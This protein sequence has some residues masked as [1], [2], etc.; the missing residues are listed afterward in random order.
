MTWP[1]SAAPADADASLTKAVEG[2]KSD[3]AVFPLSPP[4]PRRMLADL[5]TR[6]SSRLR[7]DP[8]QATW[9]FFL[10]THTAPFDDVR[11]RPG[12]AGVL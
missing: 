7:F 8:E 11:V 12:C 2:G 6:Y 10:N 4:V 5:T 1:E 9:Y 3:L